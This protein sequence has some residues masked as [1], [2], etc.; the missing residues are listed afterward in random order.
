MV[1]CEEAISGYGKTR[2]ARRRRERLARR[3]GPRDP[4]C[5]PYHD[6]GNQREEKPDRLRT[7]GEQVED[8]LLR[9]RRGILGQD[10]VESQ[11][12]WLRRKGVRV[13]GEVWGE[14][15]ELFGGVRRDAQC[16][17]LIRV[18]GQGIAHAQVGQ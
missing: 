9:V 15:G 17:H 13:C 14:A 10:V 12:G 1:L 18:V 6:A 4:P 8:L 11:G 3:E 5:R 2:E 16:P 7:S